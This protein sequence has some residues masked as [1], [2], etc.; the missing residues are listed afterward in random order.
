MNKE[1][2]PDLVA[3]VRCKDCKR[4]DKDL[5]AEPI[6]LINAI[7]KHGLIGYCKQLKVY[8]RAEDYCS[9]GEGE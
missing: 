4:I 9:I 6:S 3:V 5:E 7:K 2:L 1:N 8:V